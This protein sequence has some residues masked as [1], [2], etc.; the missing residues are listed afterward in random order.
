MGFS[1]GGAPQPISSPAE[2][3]RMIMRGI[4]V[5]FSAGVARQPI[6]SPAECPGMIMR[7]I[8][9]GILRRWS[10]TANIVTSRMSR[11]DNEG[12]LGWGSLQVELNSK[13]RHQQK[14]PE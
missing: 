7:G 6:S 3:P 11:N 5:G 1:A 2:C 13:S 10:S 9:V 12:E 8:G 4:G 14:V